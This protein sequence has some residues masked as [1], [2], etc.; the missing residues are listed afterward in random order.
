MTDKELYEKFASYAYD[1]GW[2]IEES[3]KNIGVGRTTLFNYK[4]GHPISARVRQAM[5]I[6]V[7]E[8][9]PNPP[10][11]TDK[12]LQYVNEEWPALSAEARGQIIHIIEKDIARK[13]SNST[14]N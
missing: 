2:T 5:L 6:L 9:I 1:H 10:P 13:Q 8:A 14:H 7:A 4:N 3:A 11:I 12:L